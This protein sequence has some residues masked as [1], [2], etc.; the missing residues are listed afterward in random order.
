MRTDTIPAIATAMSNS[1]IGII[2]VSGG[3][4]IKIVD[5]IYRD[6]NHK[7]VLMN[8]KS[9]TI[10]YGFIFD[11][12]EIVDEVMVSVMKKPNSFTTEDT[13]E[14]NCHGGILIMNRILEI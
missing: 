12:E 4:S 3:E 11:G 10:H 6:K 8:F 5:S 13:V 2:R 7:K 9:N 1:G 14:I